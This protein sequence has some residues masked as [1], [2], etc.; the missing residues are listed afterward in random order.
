[1]IHHHFNQ[2]KTSLDKSLTVAVLELLATSTRTRIV[3]SRHLI[4]NKR[5]VILAYVLTCI[6]IGGGTLL[7]VVK[8]YLLFGIVLTLCVLL[9]SCLTNLLL[10]LHFRYLSTC[11]DAADTVVHIVNHRVEQLGALKLE[12]EQRILLLV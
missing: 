5:S 11:E 10:S 3:A 8:V 1:M 7:L 9:G 2:T 6:V 12:D 4:L